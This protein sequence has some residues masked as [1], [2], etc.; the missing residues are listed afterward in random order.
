MTVL[1]LGSP[2]SGTWH[3]ADRTWTH[4]TPILT[5]SLPLVLPGE[6]PLRIPLLPHRSSQGALESP[7]SRL[8]SIS[9]HGGS[10][11][12][13]PTGPDGPR[14]LQCSGSDTPHPKA[15][16]VSWSGDGTK[17]QHLEG[18]LPSRTSLL[19]IVTEGGRR[20]KQQVKLH[21]LKVVFV[22]LNRLID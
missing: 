9:S 1:L 21:Q 16:S 22:F 20:V 18:N 8:V 11:G 7:C 14:L 13:I 19:A 10:G 5:R 15:W 17:A 12:P 6:S 3:Y 2:W 4:K